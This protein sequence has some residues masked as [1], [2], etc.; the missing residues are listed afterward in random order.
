MAIAVGLVLGL[1][2]GLAAAATGNEWLMA[3]AQGSAPFGTVF[4]NAIRMVVIPLIVTII[5]TS[6]ASLGDPRK[7]G[8][9]G[10]LTLVFYWITLIPCIIIG[11]AAMKLGLQ[12]SS[13]IAMPAADTAKI[14]PLTGIVEFLT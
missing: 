13:D 6:V 12:F 10:G 3:I 5:F 7:L 14:P 4:I 11:V 2:V 8:R 9:I 1:A